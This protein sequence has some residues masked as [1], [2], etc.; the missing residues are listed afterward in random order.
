M[1]VR[2]GG[3]HVGGAP[4]L[5]RDGERRLR[6][7]VLVGG[8]GVD[9][10][11]VRCAS[12]VLNQEHV[13]AVR[14][15]HK[16]SQQSGQSTSAP[17]HYESGKVIQSAGHRT[18]GKHASRWWDFKPTLLCAGGAQPAGLHLEPVLQARI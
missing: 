14:T 12:G 4:Y 1:L 13:A 8:S 15:L 9:Q 17:N 5:G 2:I 11:A 18:K 7:R 6:G 3:A 16:Q 10:L